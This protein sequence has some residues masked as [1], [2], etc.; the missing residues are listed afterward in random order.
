MANN[1]APVLEMP[2]DKD[3]GVVLLTLTSILVSF[4]IITTV[5]R[6]WTRWKRGVIGW[7]CPTRSLNTKVISNIR[8]PG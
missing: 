4:V 6:V 8:C 5:L 7:V 3:M 2:E 1:G